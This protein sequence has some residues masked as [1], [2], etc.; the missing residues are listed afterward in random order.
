MLKNMGMPPSVMAINMDMLLST[1]G[2]MGSPFSH[3]YNIIHSS[4]N[5]IRESTSFK[6]KA[7]N[8]ELLFS[9]IGHQ[10]GAVPF[11]P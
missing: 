1:H 3:G 7:F 11:H 2:H 10:Y 5:E 8:M 4:E 6:S 9:T